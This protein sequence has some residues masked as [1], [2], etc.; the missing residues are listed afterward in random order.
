MNWIKSLIAASLLAA[1]PAFA[2]ETNQPVYNAVF[3]YED[4]WYNIQIIPGIDRE[5]N[6]IYLEGKEGWSHIRA[7]CFNHEL[8]K[9][10]TNGENH[11][12]ELQ[13]MIATE[14]CR[15]SYSAQAEYWE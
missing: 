15:S 13:E 10:E 9:L 12:P 2:T 3:D 6:Y 7:V 4:N 11:P 1:T 8:V 14:W 5:I